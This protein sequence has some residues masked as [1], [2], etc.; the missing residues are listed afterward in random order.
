MK[1]GIYEQ[2]INQLIETY[3]N[4]SN[5]KI[6]TEKLNENE[7]PKI[8]SQYIAKIIETGLNNLN[9]TGYDIYEQIKLCNKIIEIIAIATN[10]EDLRSKSIAKMLTPATK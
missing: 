8:L 10:H 4:D 6:D 2:I 9:D 3:L 1:T 5:Y 7:S